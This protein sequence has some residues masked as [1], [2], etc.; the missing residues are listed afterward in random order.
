MPT[1]QFTQAYVV[2]DA[3]AGTPAEEHYT[4]GQ[5]VEVSEASAQHFCARGRAVRVAAPA[6]PLAAVESPPAAAVEAAPIV[7]DPQPK[8]SKKK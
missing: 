4:A 3:R 8:A 1:I 6:P 2:Q 5:V 7:D